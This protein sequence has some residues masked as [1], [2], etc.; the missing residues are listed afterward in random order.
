VSEPRPADGGLLRRTRIWT[1]V[2]GAG[3]SGLAI[4]VASP[5]AALSVAAG[6]TLALLNL[7]ALGGIVGRMVASVAPDGPEENAPRPSSGQSRPRPRGGGGWSVLAFA[8]MLV[9][10]GL[11]G[12]A[13]RAGALRPVAVVVGYLCLVAAAVVAALTS[14]KAQPRDL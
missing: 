3:A 1:A 5:K 10:F 8:K 11:L 13:F 7:W 9:L 2:L 6:A 14:G 12:L 4:F